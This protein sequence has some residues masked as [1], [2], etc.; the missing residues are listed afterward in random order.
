MT[1]TYALYYVPE[2]GKRASKVPNSETHSAKHAR[3]KRAAMNV[4]GKETAVH[5]DPAGNHP[6]LLPFGE[7]LYREMR[8]L[9]A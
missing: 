4:F 7:R 5:S 8:W 1:T 2:A 3:T 6:D 9:G